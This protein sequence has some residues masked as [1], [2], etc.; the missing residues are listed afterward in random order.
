MQLTEMRQEFQVQ[1]GKLEVWNALLRIISAGELQDI[2][3]KRAELDRMEEQA[4]VVVLKKDKYNKPSIGSLLKESVPKILRSHETMKECPDITPDVKEIRPRIAWKGMG[5][6]R[7]NMWSTRN[8][9]ADSVDECSSDKFPYND[10]TY[11]ALRSSANL[12]KFID[13]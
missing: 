3:E 5:V 1:S 11:E 6:V 13:V 4:E 7:G 10:T 8:S 2:S 12:K 9:T